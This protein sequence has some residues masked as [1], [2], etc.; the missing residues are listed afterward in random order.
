V[1]EEWLGQRGAK[2]GALFLTR[3]SARLS[4]MQL[5]KALQ[6]VATQANANRN[7]DGERISVSPH[8]LRHTFLRK[9]AEEKGVH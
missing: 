7:K 4:R 6:R 5:F 8:V 1:L 2:H 3:T 9:L